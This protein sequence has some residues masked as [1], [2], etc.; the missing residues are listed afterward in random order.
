LEEILNRRPY[1]RQDIASIVDDHGEVGD[2]NGAINDYKEA[3]GLLPDKPTVDQLK[4]LIAP[5]ETKFENT[6][7]KYG[8]WISNFNTK[9]LL[10]RDELEALMND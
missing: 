10:L 1:Y 5:S 8:T 7:T 3:L 6:I 4:R 9:M 2:I